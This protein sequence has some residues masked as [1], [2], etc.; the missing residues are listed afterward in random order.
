M[1]VP[2][3]PVYSHR[4]TTQLAD[5]NASPNEAP[6]SNSLCSTPVESIC[7]LHEQGS[8]ELI[9]A[10]VTMINKSRTSLSI[11]EGG[12]VTNARR[13]S[14]M[15]SPTLDQPPLNRPTLDTGEHNAKP[16]NQQSVQSD[17]ESETD[18]N[19]H[20]SSTPSERHARYSIGQHLSSLQL[21]EARTQQAIKWMLAPKE[22]QGLLNYGL[23]LRLEQMISSPSRSTESTYSVPVELSH[24]IQRLLHIIILNPRLS[25][26]DGAVIQSVLHSNW[27]SQG[28]AAR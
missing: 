28:R 9:Q 10:R 12:L 22:Q 23:G 6:P 24:R 26:Y 14:L 25:D 27:G 13:F 3:T 19:F 15:P 17:T 8:A 11:P 2:T 4:N 18:P 5:I 1:P 7:S 20:S 16:V 21:D